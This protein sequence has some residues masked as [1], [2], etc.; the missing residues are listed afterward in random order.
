MSVHIR[1]I[2]MHDGAPCHRSK[3]VKEFLEQENVQVLDWP[4]NSPYLNPIEN[5]WKLMKA[6][7]AEK[8][9]SKLNELQQVIKEVWVQELSSEYC[10]KLV[11]SM[12]GRM[13]V[14]IASKSG[15]AKY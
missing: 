9:P 14:V 15:H 10:Y 8:Y 11:S 2:F 3:A 5:L 13:Q 7:V 1:S 12:P 4:G 6:K